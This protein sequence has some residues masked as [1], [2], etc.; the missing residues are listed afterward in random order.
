MK[1]STLRKHSNGLETTY[2]FL[3]VFNVVDMP[4]SIFQVYMGQ[5]RNK[6]VLEMDDSSRGAN[7]TE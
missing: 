7:W 6:C 1:N 4:I 2:V 5:L 3:V